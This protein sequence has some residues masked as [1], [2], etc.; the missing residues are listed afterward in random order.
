MEQKKY[1]HELTN[2]EFDDAIKSHA[3]Y[4]DFLRPAWCGYPNALT[5]YRKRNKM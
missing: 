2:E 5:S 1:F 4:N 3:K